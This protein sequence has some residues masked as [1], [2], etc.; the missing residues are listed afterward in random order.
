MDWLRCINK[1]LTL[2][3]DKLQQGDDN[4]NS[5]RDIDSIDIAKI[6]LS[7]EVGVSS[8][9]LQ[10][11]FP[12]MTGYTIAEYVRN[13]KLYLAALD[14]ISN[15][16]KVIDVAYKYGYT[17]PESFTKAFIRFHEISPLKLKADPSKLKVFLPMHVKIDIRGGDN[18]DYTIVKE[19]EL[20][21]IGYCYNVSYDE[22][23]KLIP[24]LWYDYDQK[25]LNP[26]LLH[27]S[28]APSTIEDKAVVDNRIGEFGICFDDNGDNKTFTY[29]IGGIYKGGEVPSSMQ[30][31]TIEPLTYAKF[32]I[33]GPMPGALQATNKKIFNEWLPGNEKYELSKGIS[34]EWYS[35]GDIQNT[36][37][38]SEI[39]VPV[40]EIKQ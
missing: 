32:A 37:Y 40:K 18:M 30:I 20:K 19:N 33:R 7:K 12:L 35:C 4:S 16:M 23:Y 39:W 36:D 34:V 28:K 5:S 6:D 11:A 10:K 25:Y 13:R 31:M 17:T 2:I 1:T 21:L 22:A 8:M 29:M 38:R 14:I 26:L 9:Y 15:R 3:E 24:K 27:K